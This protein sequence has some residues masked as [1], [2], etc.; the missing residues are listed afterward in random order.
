[1][2]EMELP[3]IPVILWA[4]DAEGDRR[5]IEMALEEVERRPRIRFVADGHE[6]LRQ[7][8]T[9]R[10]DMVVLDLSMPGMAGMEVLQALRREEATKEL[11][12]I[13]FSASQDLEMI[14][15]CG[16]LGAVAIVHKPTNLDSFSKAVQ[17]ITYTGK[18]WR[19]GTMGR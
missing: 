17:R 7:V 2:P 4:E 19:D 1:M 15:A 11:P 10:P 13:V 3:R 6:L 9:E 14:A 12:V 5:L 8:A 18:L 16:R